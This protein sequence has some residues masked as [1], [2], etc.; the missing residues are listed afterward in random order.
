MSPRGEERPTWRDPWP[1]RMR[2][3]ER[4]WSD[5]SGISVVSPPHHYRCRHRHHQHRHHPL[6]SNV[7]GLVEKEREEGGGMRTRNL[8][9]RV[10]RF[11][12]KS[13]CCC[14]CRIEWGETGRNC[15][16]KR[17]TQRTR[18]VCGVVASAVWGSGSKKGVTDFAFRFGYPTVTR[19]YRIPESVVREPWG[20]R[21]RCAVAC[22]IDYRGVRLPLVYMYAETKTQS[23]RLAP[24]I[25]TY[26]HTHGYH[27]FSE[28]AC[29]LPFLYTYIYI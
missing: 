10:S 9:R 17:S 29:W 15:F 20:M 23:H 21:R 16:W 18:L 19:V 24:S 7:E 8:G 26:T 1:E 12:S 11:R 27:H 25:V 14:C 3:V 13:C 22:W 4:L 28:Q 2:L 5:L 6:K